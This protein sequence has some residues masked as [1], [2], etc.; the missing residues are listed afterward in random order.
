MIFPGLVD[1]G[2]GNR[3][4][5]DIHGVWRSRGDGVWGRVSLPQ[6]GSRA[7]LW[8]LDPGAISA[9]NSLHR[10]YATLHPYRS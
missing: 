7:E 10:L 1:T 4:T 6:W 9:L 3:E 5:V 2:L 8:R